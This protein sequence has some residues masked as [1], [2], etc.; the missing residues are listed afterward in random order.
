MSKPTL[1]AVLLFVLLIAVSSM[2]HD[3]NI[4][5]DF[6]GVGISYEKTFDHNDQDPWKGYVNV[7]VTN[8]SSEDWGDFHFKITEVPGYAYTNVL[9]VVTSPYEPN[10]SQT[11]D[12]GNPWDVDNSSSYGS[13]LD[14]YFYGD[15]IEIGDTATFTIYTDNTADKEMFGL[16]MY[17]TPVPEPATIGLLG[18]AG[19]AVVR[20]RKR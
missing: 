5:T 14:L 7:S 12:A 9:F 16:C 11:L 13:T 20:R 3:V 19:L 8:T 6:S 17:P 2:A 1:L 15:P 10:S 18:L 4:V